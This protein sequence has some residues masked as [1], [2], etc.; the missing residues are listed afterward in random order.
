VV[1]VPRHHYLLGAVAGCLQRTNDGS[2]RRTRPRSLNKHKL[3]TTVTFSEFPAASEIMGQGSSPDL[4]GPSQFAGA[5]RFPALPDVGHET[6]R[7]CMQPSQL[8]P[9]STAF[10]FSNGHTTWGESG[11][12]SNSDFGDA[13]WQYSIDAE[14]EWDNYMLPGGFGGLHSTLNPSPSDFNPV[15]ANTTPAQLLETNVQSR[16][17]ADGLCYQDETQRMTN[18]LDLDY[19]FS[20]ETTIPE[21]ISGEP[22]TKSI[23]SLRF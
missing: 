3:S 13:T 15:L 10:E 22:T 20:N 12:A 7:L 8:P 18:T 6:K 19:P 11:I 9:D 1:A 21:D 17:G 5:K 23:L 2:T 4:P 14:T 16:P